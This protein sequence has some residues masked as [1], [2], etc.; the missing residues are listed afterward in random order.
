VRPCPR[1]PAGIGEQHEGEQAR[2]LAVVGQQAVDQA[3]QPNRLGCQLAALQTRPRRAGIALVEDQ[4]E[5]VEDRS[6][7]FRAVLA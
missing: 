6:E 5:H 1:R 3:G 2:H 4:V 7:P